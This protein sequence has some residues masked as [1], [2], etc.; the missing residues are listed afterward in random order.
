MEHACVMVADENGQ[1]LSN[2]TQVRADML[3]KKGQ[4][5]FLSDAPFSIRLLRVPGNGTP[6]SPP[7]GLNGN[8]KK[9]RKRKVARLR[10]RDGPDCFYCG[11]VMLVDLL[12]KADGGTDHPSNLVLAHAVCNEIASDMP[13]ISKVLLRERLREQAGAGLPVDFR[14]PV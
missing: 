9:K 2:C 10:D 3:L 1:P 6:P 5:V 4:A 13:V 8:Q 11:K 14:A 7:N 12:A